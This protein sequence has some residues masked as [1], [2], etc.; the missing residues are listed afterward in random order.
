MSEDLHLRLSRSQW[1]PEG[2]GFPAKT[3]YN[4]RGVASGEPLA[5]QANIVQPETKPVTMRMV[6][7]GKT[8]RSG[9]SFDGTT[10]TWFPDTQLELPAT[11]KIGVY[12][13]HNFDRPFAVE[14]GPMELG[15]KK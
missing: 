8:I 1:L 6:R 15:T 2:N 14:F 10:W 7:V 5:D 9:Y 4:L 13:A 12:A 11:I 3:T